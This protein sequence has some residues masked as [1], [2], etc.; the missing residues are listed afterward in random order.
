MQGPVHIR[1]IEFV[2]ADVI[3]A[4]MVLLGLFPL[5]GSGAAKQL[6]PCWPGSWGQL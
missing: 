2:L 4:I 6:S 3:T 1:Q 5:I